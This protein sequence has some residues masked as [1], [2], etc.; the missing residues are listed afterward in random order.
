MA[1]LGDEL[2]KSVDESM[3]FVTEKL[4]DLSAL[5][6][7]GYLT[8]GQCALLAPAILASKR[9]GDASEMAV[10]YLQLA[11]LDIAHGE[12]CPK[13]PE[14]HLPYSQYLR[15]AGA[16][17]FGID[18]ADMPVPTAGWLVHLDEAERWLQSKGLSVNVEGLKAELAEM[19]AADASTVA[20]SE[21]SSK[22][23]AGCT[24]NKILSADWQLPKRV[25]LERALGDVP[26]WLEAAIVC[27]GKP[28]GGSSTW[29]PAIMAVCMNTPSKGKA[30]IVSL[31]KLEKVINEFFPS[32]IEEWKEC[33]E[34]I[35]TGD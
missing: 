22:R 31:D 2:E 6:D 17:M 30:W 4:D 29:N 24:K 10:H 19:A 11:L 26:K 34:T 25:N 23:T 28:G 20:V 7:Q 13:H 21:K 18:G 15:M 3:P 33:R 35:K 14:T 9:P 8:V 12:L 1:K 27:R 5:I 16:G 32:W